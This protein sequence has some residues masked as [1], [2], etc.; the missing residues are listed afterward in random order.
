MRNQLRK[1]Y[2]SEGYRMTDLTT[3]GDRVQV[4]LEWDKRCLPR[5]SGCKKAMRINRKHVQ[6][7]T[8][9]P[10]G[11]AS[12][13]LVKYD[14][15]QGYC[16]DCGRYETVRALDVVEQRSATLRVM[17]YVSRLCRWLPAESVCEFVAITPMTAWRYDKYIL[18]TE[19]L[20]P[21]L[22]GIEALLIDE[23]HLGN[24][25]FVTIILNARTGELLW[26]AVGRGKEAV[27][28]F[29]DKLSAEQ[30]ASILA[31]GID[32]SGAYRAAVELYLPNADI[33]FDKFHLVANLGEVIDKIRRRTQAQADAEGRALLKGQ[34]YNLL[35]NRENLSTDGRAEL[36]ELLAANRDLSVVYVLKDAFKQVWTYTYRKCADKC[37][38]RWIEMATESGIAE[39]KRFANGLVEAKEQILNF[40]Q[41]R[42]TS[43]RIEAFNTLVSRVIHKACGVSDLDFLFLKLRQESLRRC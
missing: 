25:G 22:D 6:F 17:R 15:V 20:A 34:R 43:A 35:R 32:R 7:V 39:L 10:L 38:S 37:L 31:V 21:K 30:K 19:L 8:D 4:T 2:E 26:L 3:D 24:R 41:H 9:M 28:G 18:Q 29:F 36:K 16:K 12:C 40:C 11:P 13:V 42:I 1:L 14:A 27:R 33:V 5:C 23:K